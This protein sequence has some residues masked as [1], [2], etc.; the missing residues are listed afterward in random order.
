M[1][2]RGACLCNSTADRDCGRYVRPSDIACGTS[3]SPAI[4]LRKDL[5]MRN[6]RFRPAACPTSNQGHYP[7]IFRLY[8]FAA[9]YRREY[10]ELLSFYGL[11]LDGISTDVGFA[12]P[13][14]SHLS[15]ASS[16]ITQ[17]RIPTKLDPGF[18]LQKNNGHETGHPAMG[19][20]AHGLPG[21]VCRR[22]VLLW[23]YWIGRLHHASHSSARQLRSSGP[24]KKQSRGRH[25]AFGI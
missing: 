9:I 1:S 8:S 13:Q 5:R 20:G 12:Q 17:V 6:T 10:R 11:E 16:N 25:M 23:I 22:P 18:S 21:T 3:S 15:E 4:R 14:K 7:N 2:P 24:G 19:Y